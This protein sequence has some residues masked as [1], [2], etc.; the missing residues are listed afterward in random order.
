M[1]NT[2]IDRNRRT[3]NKEPVPIWIYIPCFS[4]Q[5]ILYF[6]VFCFGNVVERKIELFTIVESIDFRLVVV[7]CMITFV[8]IINLLYCWAHGHKP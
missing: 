8:L 4:I 2:V 7:I 5:F 1:K 3:V 6:L